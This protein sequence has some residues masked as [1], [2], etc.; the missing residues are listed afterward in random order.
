M[1]LMGRLI[2]M[3]VA[4]VLMA[5]AIALATGNPGLVAIRLWP[6]EKAL[7][8][9]VWLLILGSFATGLILGGLAMLA[10]LWR[11]GWRNRQLKGTIRKMEKSASA[12]PKG[13]TPLLPKA[14]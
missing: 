1:T 12:D 9:P 14:R 10:P 3:A 11:S 6:L 8:L 4:I 5:A 7:Q 2:A 13:S